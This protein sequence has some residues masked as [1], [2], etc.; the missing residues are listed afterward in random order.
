MLS[1]VFIGSR[2]SRMHMHTALAAYLS[3][4]MSRASLFQVGDCQGRPHPPGSPP[5]KINFIKGTISNT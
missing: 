3:I 5:A 4:Y 1:S 2:P